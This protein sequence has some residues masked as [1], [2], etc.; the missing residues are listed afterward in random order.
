MKFIIPVFIVSL[1]ITVLLIFVI[2]GKFAGKSA[3][4]YVT[5][6]G[7][8]W[9]FL[10]SQ[11]AVMIYERH[12]RKNELI[13]MLASARNELL[14]NKATIDWIKH[15]LHEKR[16][17]REIHS[18]GLSCVDEIRLQAIE[19][20]INSPYIYEFT[21][22]DFALD[23]VYSIYQTV[24]IYKK[25][26]PTEDAGNPTK[27]G[28]IK[29]DGIIKSIDTLVKYLDLEGIQLSGRRKWIELIQ[30]PIEVCPICKS[31][32]D[33]CANRRSYLAQKSQSRD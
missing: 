29:F 27:Y 10:L 20:L 19:N 2:E 21:S 12:K 33:L 15:L 1:T 4:I 22:K 11:I 17:G 23:K 18:F 28:Y 30:S 9:G 6:I 25:E 16:S 14:K 7:S 24:L 31:I 13:L 3:D 32:V 5:L 8:F 26:I